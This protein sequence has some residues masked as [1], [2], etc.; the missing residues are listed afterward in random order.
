MKKELNKWQKAITFFVVKKIG[1]I[2]N[3]KNV[4]RCIDISQKN[5]TKGKHCWSEEFFEMK[6]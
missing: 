3:A 1:E 6:F 4:D 2:L 5:I